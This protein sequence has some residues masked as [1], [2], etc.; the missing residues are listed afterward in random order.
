TYTPPTVFDQLD[1]PTSCSACAAPST[2]GGPSLPPPPC[3]PPT[4]SATCTPASGS[5]FPLG[6]TTVSC[7]TSDSAGRTASASFTVTL[8]PEVTASCVGTPGGPAVLPTAPGT[9]GVELSN[10]SALAGTCGG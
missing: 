9:C 8:I 4:V 10:T 1:N 7:T 2:S 3:T 5:T 6:T